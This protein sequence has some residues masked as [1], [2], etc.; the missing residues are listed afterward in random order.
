MKHV[1]WIAGVACAVSTLCAAG[2]APTDIAEQIARMQAQL[3]TM[4]VT[5]EAQQKKIDAQDRTIA[6]LSGAPAEIRENN[7]LNK[8]DAPDSAPRA[9][10]NG[11]SVKLP[12]ELPGITV[13]ADAPRQSEDGDKIGK[14]GQPSWTTQR[15][16][17]ETRAY[18]IPEGDF[19]FEYWD[20]V[21]VPRKSVTIAEQKY[22]VE[23]GLG[24]RIQ[25]D[26]YGLSHSQGNGKGFLFDEHDVEVRY[27]FADWDKIPGNPTAYAEYKFL[28]TEADHLEFKMLFSGDAGPC[29]PKLQ[30]AANAVWEHEMGLK[31][32]SSYEITGGVS[33]ELTKKLSVGAESKNEFDDDHDHRF[34]FKA[35]IL[36][37]GPS[38]Q[39]C[40]LKQMHIDFSPLI[41]MTH[42][43]PELKSTLIVGWKF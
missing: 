9:K 10:E 24:N 21:E 39:W 2:D 27:A 42:N 43:S 38:L 23:M 31:Q 36:L 19:E 3:K 41:G 16:F 40:P 34:H 5:I 8:L 1:F 32:S 25:L 26:I 22:E 18:V 17:T 14:Y 7:A 35:P 11:G 4:V 29:M 20:T 37:L 30:W 28:N 12:Y 15:R 6:Q 33:Y 13:T